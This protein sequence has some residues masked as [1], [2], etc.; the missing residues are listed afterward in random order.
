MNKKAASGTETKLGIL[1]KIGY[2][3]GEAGSQFSWTLISS[4][5]TVFYTDVVGLTPAVISMIMLVARIWDAVNDPMFGAIAENT[6]TKLGR[7]RPYILYGAPFLALFNCLSFL[8]LNIPAGAKSLWC[9]IT[10]IACG[11]AYTAVNISTGCLANCMTRSNKERVSLNAYRG[12]IGGIAAMM[13]NSLTMPMILKLGGGSTS[14]GRG[15]FL[16]AL[17][18]SLISLPFFFGCVYS[19]KEVIGPKREQKRGSTT[20]ALIRSFQY[21]MTDR[22][23]LLLILAEIAFLT[24]IFGRI[25][26]M[27][28]YFIY[29]LANP[30][31]MAKFAVAMSAGML[32][33]N[34]YAPFLLNRYNKKNV[35][36][37]SSLLQALCCVAFYYAGQRHMNSVIVGLGLLYGATNLGG[38]VS[39]TLGAEIIDDNWLRT[40]I[41]S[42][43]I[44]YSCLSFSTKLGNAIG[45]S[46][47]ILILGVVGFRANTE[48][49]AAVLRNM[50]AVINFGPAMMF[51]AAAVFFMMNSMTNARGRENEECLIEF[52]YKKAKED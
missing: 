43:G 38:I 2:G 30:G 5:L 13:V 7:Y 9:G 35:G 3:M 6:R 14:D 50:N 15:Y 4:Y 24:G 11:M 46:I 32:I 18:F 49:S 23:A 40:G 22:N 41:R 47:G 8:N 27:A 52:E 39:Y 44:I 33:V 31:L 42:D 10:Y 36:A 26:I 20:R 45:G 25:N 28:Y 48:M 37:I 12:T 21:T 51:V 17:I 16:T 29:I 34:L 1:N 19:T